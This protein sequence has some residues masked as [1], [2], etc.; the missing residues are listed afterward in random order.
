MDKKTKILLYLT[1]LAAILSSFISFFFGGYNPRFAT[2][3]NLGV[4]LLF[5]AGVGYPIL[6]LGIDAIFLLIS[7]FKKDF[8]KLKIFLVEIILLGGI[9]YFSLPPLFVK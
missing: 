5:L 6:I 3:P 7:L 8:V 9:L 2:N 1:I 4:V